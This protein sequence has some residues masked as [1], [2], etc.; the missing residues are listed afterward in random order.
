MGKKTLENFG[1]KLI[2]IGDGHFSQERTVSK[3]ET[4]M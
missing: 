2:Q 3:I 1:C 4:I